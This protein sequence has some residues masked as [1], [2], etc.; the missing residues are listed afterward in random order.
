MKPL[1]EA[2]ISKVTPMIEVTVDS[3]RVSLMNQQ[4]IIVLK[5]INDDRFLPIWIG[6][7]EAEAITVELQDAQKK[8][9]LTHDLLKTVIEQLGAKIDYVLISDVRND[10]YYARIVL[11]VNGEK[12]EIDSRPSDGIA[13]AVRAKCPIF[14]AQSVMDRSGKRPEDDVDIEDE[15]I[16]SAYDD[17]PE[18]SL[19]K[20]A[21]TPAEDVDESRFS[22]FADFVNSLNLDELEDDDDN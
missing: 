16:P 5:D 21:E 18:T 9:P 20:P 4:R 6:Q 2:T 19:S 15:D 14:V 13:L 22:A 10:V 7:F 12:Q 3:I 17:E 8:R 1:C 11:E